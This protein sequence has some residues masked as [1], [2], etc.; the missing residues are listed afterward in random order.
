MEKIRVN[1]PRKF[2]IGVMLQNGTERAILPGSF[3]MLEK[4]DI[5]YLASVAPMLFEGEK[6][7]RLSDRNLAVELG[8]I[9]ST[10]QP[11]LD[12]EEIRKN[13]SQRIG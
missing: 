11:V 5:E 12:D 10:E 4:E 2:A 7:L 6:Q 13:L 9:E 3:V 8:F 1:N